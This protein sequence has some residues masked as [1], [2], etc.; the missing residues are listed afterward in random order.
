MV[1]EDKSPRA[2]TPKSRWDFE[3]RYFEISL[4]SSFLLLNEVKTSLC[5][6]DFCRPYQFA[7]YFVSFLGFF[8][9]SS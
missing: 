3:C 1:M 7:V 9:N 8:Q 5:D 2:Q 4:P 6:F